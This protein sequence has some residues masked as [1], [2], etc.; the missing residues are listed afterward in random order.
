MFGV[1]HRSSRSRSARRSSG[2]VLILNTDGSVLVDRRRGRLGWRPTLPVKP[3]IQIALVVTAV[4]LL[5]LADLGAG[6]YHQRIANLRDGPWYAWLGSYILVL[7]PITT[8]VVSD[9]TRWTR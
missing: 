4:K 6:E 1:F 5:L 3:I 2:E 8:N 9:L 7:D